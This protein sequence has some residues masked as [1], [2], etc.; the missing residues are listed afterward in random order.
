[1]SLHI[2]PELIPHKL[3]HTGVWLLPVK[4]PDWYYFLKKSNHNAIENKGFISSVDKPLRPLVSWLHKRGIKTTPSC[5][6][7]HMAER[8]L[9]KI[10]EQLKEDG[11]EIRKE[12]LL[13]QDI[14]SGEIFLHQNPRYKLPW[15]KRDFLRKAVVYQCTGVV[16]IKIPDSKTVKDKVNG[17]NIPLVSASESK[18][19]LFVFVESRTGENSP[20]W[21]AV[22]KGLKKILDTG[23]G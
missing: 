8:S 9:G 22:T 23:K 14:E 6:G 2:T 1:M 4:R 17:L 13:M 21:K 19:I 11:K 18:G 3:F 7:H 16:G 12:G 15:N 5:S 10:Y 20:A